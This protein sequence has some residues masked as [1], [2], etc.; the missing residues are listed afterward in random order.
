MAGI[1]LG[2]VI[3]RDESRRLGS[4]SYLPGDKVPAGRDEGCVIGRDV[5]VGLFF[6]SL[7]GRSSR[8]S[9]TS[10]REAPLSS[11]VGRL[12]ALASG[13]AHYL[14]AR[15]DETNTRSLCLGKKSPSDLPTCRK[16]GLP[17]P[18]DCPPRSRSPV[19]RRTSDKFVASASQRSKGF[20]GRPQLRPR[21]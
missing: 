13:T 19:S 7:G 2:Q 15:R 9:A 14:P 21:Y 4:P 3:G 5:L 20:R 12:Q 1:C 10:R 17:A 8:R 6:C 11:P 16:Q 18:A